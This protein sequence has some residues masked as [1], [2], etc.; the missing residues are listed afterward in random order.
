[1]YITLSLIAFNAQGQRKNLPLNHELN[2][3]IQHGLLSKDSSAHTSIRPYIE[4]KWGINEVRNVQVDSGLYYYDFTQK[5]FKEHLVL[6]QGDDYRLTVDPLGNFRMGRDISD[7]L[8][9]MVRNT[10]AIRVQGDLG[11]NFS[12]ETFFYENQAKMPR[13][14]GEYASRTGTLP[15]EG[16]VKN[17]GSE[18]LDF[19]YAM[20]YISYS[21]MENWN[22]QVGYGKQ[23][24]GNGYRSMLLSDFAF[25][26]PYV[27]T[28]Y[29]F[30]Q[31]KFQ[32]AST[33]AQ[34][35]SLTRLPAA[36][37][38]E[39]TYKRKLGNFH[40][41]SFKPFSKLELGVFEGAVFKQYEDTVG[42]VPAHF[43]AYSPILG[44]SLIANGFESENNVLL[45]LNILYR[46]FKK[47]QLYGQ[48][49]LDN[50]EEQKMGWQAG[51]KAF[52]CFG[53]TNLYLQLEV[54]SANPYT[55][56]VS[57]NNLIQ[58]WSHMSAPLAH[59]YGASFHEFVGIAYYEK[60]KIFGQLKTSSGVI[61][62]IGNGYQNDINFPDQYAGVSE[63]EFK[64]IYNNVQE[65]TFG[66]KFNVKTNLTGFISVRN[67][68]RA[69]KVGVVNSTFISF[70]MRTNLNNLYYDF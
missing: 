11:S 64:T 10:R 67:R 24:I 66:Y 51:V 47:T 53:M 6:I 37:T 8:R 1:M 70:G 26:Y 36:T 19:G 40:Y 56:A 16:R 58:N 3:A 12:F 18:V 7:S 4:G 5:L 39:A 23:F 59:P 52:D 38:P 50:P 41:L 32:Y 48:L 31:G 44:S 54:N 45:G 9:I 55:Y 20:G 21:P 63:P 30:G 17:V 49:V 15:G 62:S 57:D 69:E 33:F 25:N 68:V 27:R 35:S 65:L 61:R 28:T 34:L 14:I 29:N 22:F 43:S 42:T 2:Y 60:E 46:I 13:Y